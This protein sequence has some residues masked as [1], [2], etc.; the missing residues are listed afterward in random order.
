[1]IVDKRLAIHFHFQLKAA[2]WDG[3]FT[4]IWIAAVFPD[5]KTVGV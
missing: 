1:M 2:G 4:Q 3:S 5:P